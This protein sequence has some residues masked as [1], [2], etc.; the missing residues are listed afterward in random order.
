MTTVGRQVEEVIVTVR[1][2]GSGK[3]QNSFEDQR[4]CQ[5]ATLPSGLGVRLRGQEMSFAF[6]SMIS[7]NT[8]HLNMGAVRR[9]IV[10]E[11]GQSFKCNTLSFLTEKASYILRFFAKVR[12]LGTP[13]LESPGF[14]NSAGGSEE[15]ELIN[16]WPQKK[17]LVMFCAVDGPRKGYGLPRFLNVICDAGM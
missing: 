2:H 8:G 14:L 17:P 11:K 10:R 15:N 1:F 3:L 16:I 6:I 13:G 7:R 5:L 9:T 4:G 12:C